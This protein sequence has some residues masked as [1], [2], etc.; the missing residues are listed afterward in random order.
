MVAFAMTHTPPHRRQDILRLVRQARLRE[1]CQDGQRN[2]AVARRKRTNMKTRQDHIDFDRIRRELAQ[3]MLL[4]PV[5]V[6]EQAEL[7]ERTAKGRK[8]SGGK[9]KY[10]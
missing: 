10:P 3:P 4:P 1:Y 2:T 7:I 8:E 9:T 6:H 5:P